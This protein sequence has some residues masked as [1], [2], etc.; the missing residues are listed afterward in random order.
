VI[1]V[2]TSAFCA[3]IFDEPDKSVFRSALATD[4]LLVSAG[5]WIELQM[6]VA[7]HK[8]PAADLVVSRLQNNPRLDIVP[9]DALQVDLANQGWRKFGRGNHAAKLNF[10]DLFAYALAKSRDLPLLFKGD[11]FAQTDVRSVL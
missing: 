11:D 8:G 10:G 5:T 4:T 1:V 3:V 2:D 7:S 6:V 9:V